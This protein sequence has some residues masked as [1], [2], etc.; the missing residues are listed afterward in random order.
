M[1][2]V[3]LAQLKTQSRQ[4]AD[5]E[6]SSGFVQ[7]PE[8]ITLI[9]LAY[10][11]LYDL[12]VSRFEDYNLT[13][14]EVTVST[15]AST[16]PL[17]SDFYKLRGLDRKVDGQTDWYSVH[18][19]NW[20]DRNKRDRSTIRAAYGMYDTTY[21]VVKQSI[22]LLPSESA[23][24]TYRLW[25]IPAYTKLVDDSDTVDGVN[26]WEDYI[27]VATAIKMLQKEESSTTELEREKA[28]LEARIIDMAQQ[29]DAD[30][31]E[32][33]ADVTNM[34]PYFDWYP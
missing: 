24:G 17:P 26:G 32:T 21:R 22:N 1:Q 16:I 20:K 28:A 13:S 15:G 27:V 10:A 6:D 23:A 9:N 11:E 25:Y 30:M 4:R 5:M 7:D 3:T 34:N 18:K 31:P 19:F 29:R 14:T 8:L 33:V 2:T 12:I